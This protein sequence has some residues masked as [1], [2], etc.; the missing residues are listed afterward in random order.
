[1]NRVAKSAHPR[2]LCLFCAAIHLS[3]FWLH[4]A[5]YAQA[6]FTNSAT[7]S[8]LFNGANLT[9]G[10]ST[11]T[12]QGW[13]TL[14]SVDRLELLAANS[15]FVD[16]TP[17]PLSRQG[18]FLVPVAPGASARFY[19]LLL[20]PL[21]SYLFNY[22][23]LSDI[24]PLGRISIAGSGT[25]RMFQYTHDT[26]NGGSGPLEIQPVYN[27]VSGNY[28]GYQHIYFYQSGT[29]T[30][31]K[32]IP[33]AGAF[34]FDAA[35]GHFHFPFASY[36]LYAAN[37]DGTIGAPVALSTKTGFC[38]ADSFI[39]D[40]SLP[41]AGAFGN[42][43]S[44]NDPTS[45]RGLSIGAVDEYDQTDEG[46]AIAIGN[47]PDG[48]YWL[49]S[50][51]D[52][53]DYLAEGN[54]TNNETDVEVAVSGSS[55]QVLQTVQPVLSLPPKIW[56]TSPN[57]GSVTGVVNL[58]A[59]TDVTGGSGV[60]F[61]V[62]GLPFGSAV[63]GPGYTLPWDTGMVPNGTHWLA[64]RI[65]DATGHFGTAPVVFVTVTN[66]STIP[67]TVQL[68][69]PDPGATVSAVVTV[70][71]NAAAA[72]GVPS[73]Q[74]YVDGVA[75]GVPVTAPPFLTLW[76]TETLAAGLHTL[77]ASASDQGGLTST[78]APV[79]VTVDN[80]NAA[81][82]IGIDVAVFQDSA[83]VMQTPAFSTSTGSDLLVAFVAYDGPDGTPQTATVTGAGLTWQLAKRSNAQN[84]TAE[85]WVAKATDFLSSVTVS[86]R[87]GNGGYH[88]SLSVL[89]FTNAAGPG[90]VG[91][92]SAPSG[93][94]DIY[95]PGVFAG[96]WVFAIG[97]DWDNAIGRTPVSGQVL[98]H[99]RLDATTGDSY[100]VQSTVAPSAADALVDIH[101]NAPLTDR[102]NYA[103]IEIVATK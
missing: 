65:A 71:A 86:S 55:V 88:G 85:I 29:W 54:K 69:S 19:R 46:Q 100:W 98:V 35:H 103:A 97:N 7:L 28:Q 32:T 3:T 43:G 4:Q 48:H 78:S 61:L 70:S 37:P 74:F 64:A 24:I 21:P 99:Q 52:P 93:A 13:V 56:L 90:I 79:I 45:L 67:P 82:L 51:V 95:L 94:P 73:V 5:L 92:A 83:D 16:A 36:G 53:Y 34:V 84:G 96:N 33:V 11:T 31:V 60:Q 8:V 42:W 44:C 77:T 6:G 72:L 14:L 26:F 87:P 27:P 89:A 15:Q 17:V 75:L 91:Q 9:V 39:Y 66:Q 62:D 59:S 10:Y 57:A 18:Q 23:D 81:K 1:M 63:L 58:A 49:R 41:N 2:A 80:S 50:M 47:L 30:L 76:D 40:P 68:T 25:N 38:I 20:E 22:P 102:W 101:D 12:T